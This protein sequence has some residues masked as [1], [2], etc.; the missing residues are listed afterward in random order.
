M[1][2]QKLARQELPFRPG[3]AQT[4]FM[5]RAFVGDEPALFR[6]IGMTLAIV[7]WFSVFGGRSGARQ[8][9]VESVVDRLTLVP[10][11]L[12]ALGLMGMFPNVLLP[13]SLLDPAPGVRAPRCCPS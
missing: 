5:E 1:R 3:V 8:M 10:L 4:V 13:F 2:A 11:V 7:S 12:L 6:V 9:V